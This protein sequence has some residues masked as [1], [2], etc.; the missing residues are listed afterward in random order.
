MAIHAMGSLMESLDFSLA[1]ISGLLVYVLSV[2][3]GDRMAMGVFGVAGILSLLLP[4][5]T[6]A[7]FFLCFFG[8]Y[9]VAQKKIRKLPP[10][11]CRI[12]KFLLFNAVFA[13]LLFLSALVTQTRELWWIYA[14][15]AVLGNLCFVLYDLLLDRFLIWYL[16]KLRK[17]LRL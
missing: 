6:P 8:W 14:A 11:L 17:R 2:E 9:P 12:I 4:L 10:I 7:V 5:K 3:Y 16:L 1:V 13:L 15:L